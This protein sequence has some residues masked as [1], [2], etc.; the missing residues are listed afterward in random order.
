MDL[1]IG[2]ELDQLHR[3]FTPVVQRFHPQAGPAVVAYAVQIMVEDAVTLQQTTA[4]S[5]IRGRSR[6]RR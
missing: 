5:R 2:G 1:V 6:V 3:A 4:M